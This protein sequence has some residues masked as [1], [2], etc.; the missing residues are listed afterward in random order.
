MFHCH[1]ISTCINCGYKYIFMSSFTFIVLYTCVI[2]YQNYLFLVLIFT[3]F[4]MLVKQSQ[5]DYKLAAMF[6]SVNSLRKRCQHGDPR[7][8][9]KF[10]EMGAFKWETSGLSQ[11]S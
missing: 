4:I 8:W 2:S 10:W 1:Y 9:G 11:G 5:L 3:W 7:K 6:W